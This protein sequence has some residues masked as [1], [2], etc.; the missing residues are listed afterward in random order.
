MEGP[1]P[2]PPPP[3]KT[4]YNETPK[5]EKSSKIVEDT[6]D[7]VKKKVKELAVSSINKYYKIEIS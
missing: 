6:P 3:P 1:P 5:K 7:V 4:G 2:P